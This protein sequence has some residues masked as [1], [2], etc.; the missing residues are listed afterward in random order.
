MKKTI[1]LLGMAAAV[2]LAFTACNKKEEDTS[3]RAEEIHYAT[4]TLGKDVDTKTMVVEGTTT[5]TYKWCEGDDKYLHVYENGAE[6]TIEEFTLSSDNTKATLVV[7][8]T[9][10]SAPYTYEAKYAKDFTNTKKPKIQSEQQPTKESFD[11]A[12]DI[13]FSKEIKS[14]TAATTL[15]F[16]MGR[17]VTVNKMILTGLE[18]GEVI[19]SVE[20]TL[21]K[22][23]VGNISYDETEGKYT[24]SAGGKKITINYPPTAADGIVPSNG[25]FPVYFISAPV[26][27]APLV[28]V[29]VKTDKN[30]YTKAGNAAEGDPFYGKAITFAVGAFTPFFMNME[31][32]GAP[33][34]TG[35]P[36][37]LVSS[38]SDLQ[39][40]A[41]YLIVA[42]KNDVFYALGAQAGNNRTATSIPA[43]VDGVITIDNTSTPF[44]VTITAVGQNW[45]II[46]N[47]PN[48]D[49][50]GQYIYNASSNK[51]YLRSEAAPDTDHKAEWTIAI[52]DGVATINNVG[53]TD[54]GCLV[55]NYNGGSP[56]FNVYASLGNYSK[57]S[58]YIEESSAIV[59]ED[60]GLAF[61]AETAT[62]VYGKESSFVAPTL[63]NP[64]NLPITWSS[65]NEEVATIDANGSNL[66]FKGNGTT[67]I[68]AASEKT[69]VYSAGSVSYELTVSGAPEEGSEGN[70]YT[71]A[72]ALAVIEA[73][74][75]NASTGVVYTSGIICEVVAFKPADNSITY[76][77][78]ADGKKE[79]YIQIYH[80]KGLNGA[81]FT[82]E[83]NLGVGDVV[84]VKGQM[85]KFVDNNNKVTPE[86]DEGSE[87]YSINRAAFFKAMLSA[88]EIPYTGGNSITLSVYSTV[89]WTASINGGASLKV[90]NGAAAATVS[91]D[92]DTEVTVI[93]P[94]NQAGATYSIT[95]TA[96][97]LT[98]P[99]AL[100]I[101]QSAQGE[102]PK[103][104]EN[105]PY[106][107]SEAAALALAGNTSEVYAAG[108]ITSITSA[109]NS[110][111]NNIT[112]TITD[113]GLSTSTSFTIYRAD[114]N[115]ADDFKI[116]DW[117]KYKGTLTKY[118]TTPEFAQGP[119]LIA[120]IHAP[121]ITPNGGSFST[122]SVSVTIAAD[123]DC[124]I[125]YTLDESDPTLTNGSVYSAAISLTAT[126]TIKAIA[127]KDGI[128]TGIVSKT[129]T[130]VSSDSYQAVF[131]YP[132]IYASTTSGSLDLDGKSDT[133]DG[134]TI[135]Y[136]KV[137]GSN[138]PK[139]Y[140][141]GTNFRIYNKSTMTVSAPSGKVITAIDFSQ[142]TTSW[143]EGAM[144]GD[145][146]T[147][148][149]AKQMW[150]H[151]T[152]VNSVV[153]TITGTFKFTKIVV[154]YK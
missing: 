77:I 82:N 119:T 154:T 21:D 69:S 27:D 127:T 110:Q 50:F 139:Y 49:K 106:T 79:N 74:E 109:Y 128:V 95:F 73:L 96:T 39:D 16:T 120:Q 20:F 28:S 45:Y 56:L 51:S 101:T 135:A 100:T 59:L 149:D 78:S 35:T 62:G 61:N 19:S 134:I 37:T 85:K 53:N 2:A 38:Q 54:R 113:D 116:G 23:M 66:S 103:G 24:C 93:I 99:E 143:V 122:E 11:P 153:L 123:N 3:N 76:N 111:Y 1:Y 140:A 36:Y 34:S 133:V 46:D 75:A 98:T 147:V 124:Q 84:V 152:G 146:G 91:G 88:N 138:T 126:T 94:E 60:P 41:S 65:S 136:A 17:P 148:S 114:A 14:E 87:L 33:I 7:S 89:A 130:K 90:G 125:R 72:E 4:I 104:S 32:Y 67:T 80:G 83:Y 42:S 22:H 44:P 43:P 92:A 129:F 121:S 137:S 64:H 10:G 52:A 132:T 57:L 150:T 141:N 25:Q 151:T 70:P 105:N 12:A 58:L 47:Y 115:S 8:F 117:V 131:D 31:G 15:S 29:V 112:Y 118:N 18:A 26:E 40:G 102:A 63:T 81:D 86:F 97:G 144:S 71:V 55:M 30:V 6:G 108:I 13:L 107:A 9:G 68:T 142:G 48:S 5:A 145:S